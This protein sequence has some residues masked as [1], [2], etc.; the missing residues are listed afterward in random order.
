[1]AQLLLVDDERVVV[2]TLA[3]SLPWEELGISHIYRA[4]SGQEALQ[5]LATH[6]I[7]VVLTDIR[8]PEMSGLEL[9]QRI[10]EL[11]GKTKCIIHSGYADFEYAKQ[12]MSSHVTEYVIKPARDLEVMAAVRRMLEALN[13]ET[14][15]QYSLQNLT[16]AVREQIPLMRSQFVMELIKGRRWSEEEF[17][18]KL[19]MMQLP[20]NA[21]DQMALIVIRLEEGISSLD[22]QSIALYEY[23]IVNIAEETLG[24]HFDVLSGRDPYDY[25]ILIAK[26]KESKS[27]ELKALGVR[28]NSYMSLLEQTAAKFQ[29]N[30]KRFLKGN[31]SLIISTDGLFPYDIPEL[32]Q[33][34]ISAI[35]RKVGND[36]NM[37]LTLQSPHT[38]KPVK[39]LKSLYETPTLI[40][41]LDMGQHKQ[42]LAKLESI[43]EEL[44]ELWDESQEHLLEVFLYL[45][46]VFTYASHRNGRL[47]E[48]LIGQDYELFFTRKP[49]L[50]VRQLKEWAFKVTNLLFEDLNRE[51]VDAKTACILQIQQFVTGKLS[52]PISLQDIADHIYMHPVY[53]SKIFKDR[54]GENLSDYI[55]RLKMEKAA[56]LLKQT[57][58][59]IYQISTMLGYQSSPYFIRIFKKFYGVT[60]Q[61]FRGS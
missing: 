23:A 11:S 1:M 51:M 49:F 31:I 53:L 44:E 13:E 52:D 12:A 54:T 36:R 14:I 21:K 38:S 28:E 30:V 26:L 39:S 17:A 35:R 10:R 61:E 18:S 16:S 34:S 55:T 42:C 60:P 9:I 15:A 32:H 59:R 19:T 37:F 41:L 25:L 7:D 3:D 50:S 47:L 24:D 29:E 45:G 43:I 22:A 46:S 58:E 4:Y 48:E 6:S 27:M 8:M 33:E 57:E 40:Q 56:F 20:F 2:N 5:L